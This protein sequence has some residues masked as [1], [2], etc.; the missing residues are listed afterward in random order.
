MRQT[1]R[2]ARSV[3]AVL[4]SLLLFFQFGNEWA[5]AGWLPLF[6]IHRL[7]ANPVWAIFALAVYFLALMLGR[8]AAQAL[9]PR[10]N[11]RK[12]LLTS[13]VAAML[14]YLLLSLT[15]SMTGA[16]IAVVIVGGGFAPIYPL[17]SETLDD[18]FSYH[19][20][21]YNGIFSIAITGAHVG[22]L[23]P[24]ICGFLPGYQVRHAA[25][26]LW[27]HRRA[28][29]GSPHHAGSSRNGRKEER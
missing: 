27:F 8:L 23:A 24:R 10:A 29:S 9:L 17:I 16:W 18:R 12:L 28:Y 19:P 15:N 22:P 11:H 26:R 13:I 5:L 2:S 25:A 14:G 7:G 6:L 21:F 3:A 4:F 20:G 1:L